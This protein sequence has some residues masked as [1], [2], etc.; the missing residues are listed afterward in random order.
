MLKASE[1]LAELLPRQLVAPSA[2]LVIADA[3][4]IDAGP[5]ATRPAQPNDALV[6]MVPAAAPSPPLELE[7]HEEEPP[8]PLNVRKPIG[9]YLIRLAVQYQWF[10]PLGT[11]FFGSCAMK[12]GT[13]LAFQKTHDDGDTS[14]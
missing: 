4:I 9:V 12:D 10:V 11:L 1:R 5:H 8:W 6:Q 3:V 13:V 14:F 2:R 7:S